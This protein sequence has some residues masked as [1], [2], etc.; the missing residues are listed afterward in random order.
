MGLSG[1]KAKSP[2][3]WPQPFISLSSRDQDGQMTWDRYEDNLGHVAFPGRIYVTGPLSSRWKDALT[4]ER[5]CDKYRVQWLAAH[6]SVLNKELSSTTLCPLI[7]HCSHQ[8]SWKIHSDVQ[9]HAFGNRWLGRGD[10]SFSFR[11]PGFSCYTCI[12]VNQVWCAV[13][14]CWN[15]DFYPAHA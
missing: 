12:V 9:A 4:C 8:T 11:L 5:R 3:T 7:W 14:S 10:L 15:M 6:M 2:F 13:L 1:P